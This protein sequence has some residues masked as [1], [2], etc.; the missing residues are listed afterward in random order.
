MKQVGS[1]ADIIRT[2]IQIIEKLE[3]LVA[4]NDSLEIDLHKLIECNLWLI[5]EGLELWSSDKPLLTVL[6]GH[7]DKIYKH[8]EKIRP[9]LLALSRSDGNEAVILE[10]KKPS[11]IITREHVTQAMEYEGLIKKH[12]PNIAF[13]TFVVGRKYDNSVLA[14]K[15]KLEL[16][17]LHFWSFDEIL[18]RSRMRFEQILKILGR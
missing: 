16:A 12:R 11:E 2:Q 6:G 10:F 18:Q 13:T 4:S 8:K 1:V 14:M 17:S 5:K 15:D 3:K 7:I 9:D